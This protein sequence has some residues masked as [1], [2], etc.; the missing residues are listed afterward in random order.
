LDEVIE[1][2]RQGQHGDPEAE[3]R[4]WLDK[5]TKMDRKGA[6]YQEMAAEDLIGFE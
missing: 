3:T 4:L 5:L 2:E 1:R 6:R